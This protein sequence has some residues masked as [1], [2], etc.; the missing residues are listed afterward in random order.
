MT[1][2]Y[3]TPNLIIDAHEW[4]AAVMLN[5]GRI[6]LAYRWRPLSLRL[7]HWSNMAKW[8]GPRPKNFCNRFWPYRLHIRAAMRS[9]V[10]RR[11]AIEALAERRGPATGAMTN[12]AA[13]RRGGRA[14]TLLRVSGNAAGV[15]A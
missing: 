9:E 3:R 2:I 6:S 10:E 13:P 4:H 15:A 14:E 7:Y 11:R 1:T 12:N 8:N 5:G